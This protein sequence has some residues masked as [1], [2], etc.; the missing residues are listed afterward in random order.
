LSVGRIDGSFVRGVELQRIRYEDD[1]LRVELGVLVVEP[2]WHELRNGSLVLRRLEAR[3]GAVTFAESARAVTESSA[4]PPSLPAIPE[5]VAVRAIRV[6]DLD[7]RGLGPDIGV[8]RL[9]GM[10][11]GPEIELATVELEAAGA[12]LA[13]SI[14]L[15]IAANASGSI[16]GRVV[17]PPAEARGAA[18]APPADLQELRFRAGFDVIVAA[19]PWYATL[20][21]TRLTWQGSA[22]GDVRSPSGR[23][24]VRPGAEPIG[25]ELSARLEAEA[26]PD[27]VALAANATLAGGALELERLRIDTLG[28]A[29]TARG[30][31]A[32]EAPTGYLSVDYQGDPSMLDERLEGRLGG[33]VDIALASAPALRI[34][35]TGELGGELGGRALDGGV[36]L[37]YVNRVLDVAQAEVVLDQGRLEVAGTISPESTDLRFSARLPRLGDWYPPAA[38]AV[39][40]SG[41]VMGETRNPSVDVDVAAERF[42]LEGSPLPPFAE[43]SVGIAGTLEAHE[44]RL[45]GHNDLGRLRVAVEQGWDGAL[46]RGTLLESVLAL[47]RA[48]TWRLTAPAEFVA[49]A[50]QVAL[51][52]ACYTGPESGRVCVEIEDAQALAVEARNLPSALAEPWLPADVR[53]AGKADIELDLDWSGPLR[54]SVMV[55]QPSLTVSTTAPRAP[56][57][58]AGARAPGGDAARSGAMQLAEIVGFELRGSLTEQALRA[59]LMA[60]LAATDDLIEGDVTLA[61]PSAEGRLEGRL[62]ASVTDLTVLDA[63]IDGVESLEGIVEAELT[64]SGSPATPSLRGSIRV[65]SLRAEL[66]PLGIAITNGRLTADAEGMEDARFEGEVCSGGCVTLVGRLRL[67]EQQAWRLDAELTGGRFELVDLPDFRAIVAPD[68]ELRADAAEWQATGTLKIEQ[69]RIEVDDVPRAA[70]RPASET[71]VHGRVAARDED[72]PLPVPLVIDVEAELGDVVFRGLGLEAELGGTLNVERTAEGRLLV[73]GTTVIEQGRFR[74]YGQELMIERGLLIFVGPPDNP[75]LD[76]RATRE[77]EGAQVG[78]TITGMA[79]NPRTMIFSDPP[80]SESEALARLVTGRSL[81]SAQPADAEALERAALGLG[82]RRMLPTLD[83]LGENLGLDELGVAAPGEEGAIVAGRQ[84]GEDVYLR[85]RHGL[86]DDFARLELIYRITDRFKLRTETGTAQ[87]IDVI[88][89]VNP[90]GAGP[91]GEPRDAE[92]DTGGESVS[93]ADVASPAPGSD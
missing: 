25:I 66:P 78:L 59:S 13:A 37:S 39:V 85:Y 46:V 27:S 24:L 28:G 47:S 54:G 48:G 91:G 43:L 21:W 56:V 33:H 58:Q 41:S 8:R 65:H 20:D 17:W 38:G 12:E 57:E 62:V 82:L 75:S 67:P 32:L 3:G 40:A 61:P 16:D 73:L 9:A 70:V 45:E 88:Y 63:F 83:R 77:V 29:I 90:R 72:R 11:D 7:V 50:A 34:T 80:M 79:R 30:A 26:L 69:G 18:G 60:R 2:A 64:A 6:V 71:V 89:E 92:V 55:R 22:A 42:A 19:Q 86:F 81:D 68:L 10:L 51:D 52:P 93:P 36:R 31:F 4:P 74:A 76:L 23:L 53:L 5:F 15:D 87:S 14:E 49:S 44:V 1:A 35:A 84:L